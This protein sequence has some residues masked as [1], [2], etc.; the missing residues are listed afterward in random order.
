MG[1]LSP[2]AA[3]VE[4]TR[5]QA[6]YA[7]RQWNDARYSWFSPGHLFMIQERERWLLAL[8]KR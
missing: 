1:G 2:E 3:R 7:K 8:L 6:V 5:I 4:E